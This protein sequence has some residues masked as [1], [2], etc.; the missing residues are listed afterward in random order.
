[1]AKTRLRDGRP[2]G[3]DRVVAGLTPDAAPCSAVC[4]EEPESSYPTI[5][6]KM[7]TRVG[8][9]DEGDK[10]YA[11]STVVVGPA[12]AW[13]V[14]SETDGSSGLAVEHSTAVVLYDGHEH[15]DETAAVFIDGVQHRVVSVAPF[16][17]R[18]EFDLVRATDGDT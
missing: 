17:D 6:V 14:R 9:T 3:P 4:A 11:F 5:T 7:R 13:S 16:P 18:L 2:C 1:M 12:V 10:R 15:V 8:Y